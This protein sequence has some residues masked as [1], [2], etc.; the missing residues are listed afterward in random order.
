MKLAFQEA[1]LALENDEYPVGAIIVVNGS[2]IS[3]AHNEEVSS[4]RTFAHAEMLAIDKALRTL[5]IHDFSE[6]KTSDITLYTTYEPCTMD[7]GL[8]ILKKVPRVVVGK[9]KSFTKM[10]KDISSRLKYR[11]KE[12]EGLYE[13]FHDDLQKARYN[14]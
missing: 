8:I 6:L 13:Y 5:D 14:S 2:V 3:K 4:N 10:L 7:E 9:R 11:L 12:R 1:A